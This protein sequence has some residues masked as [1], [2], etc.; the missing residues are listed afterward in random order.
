MKVIGIDNKQ[1]IWYLVGYTTTGDEFKSEPHLAARRLLHEMFPSDRILEE[2]PIPSTALRA[3]F[4]LP[5]RKLMIEVQGRQH[6]EYVRF[7][8]NNPLGFAQSKKRDG[9]KHRF[10]ELNK[11]T[12]V[13][14]NGDD[15]V[16][17]RN[18]I[19]AAC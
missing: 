19:N 3:D 4:Y 7:F 18:T 8:H 2:V 10:C 11:I 1:Y 16:N 12:L 17:W 9:A 5:Q 14:L 15:S 13:E 6:Y